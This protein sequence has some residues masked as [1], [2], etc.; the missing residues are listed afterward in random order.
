MHFVFDQ[1]RQL[2]HVCVANCDWLIKRLTR[3]T[4]EQLNLA[5]LGQTGAAQEV[6]HILD[7]QHAGDD[8]LVAVSPGHLVTC[9][10][11]AFLGNTDTYPLVD[12]RR[13]L[14]ASLAREHLDL[15]NRAALAVRHAQ[16]GISYLAG[17]LTEDGTQ[18]LFLGRRFRLALGG[19]PAHQDVLRPY[20]GTHIDD[21]V[22]IE[23]AQSLLADVGDISRDLFRPQPGV[24]GINLVLLDMNRREQVLA[25]NTLAD[26][27][28]VLEVATLPAHVG[29]QNILTKREF[30]VL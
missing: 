24:T 27:D 6:W 20:L 26:E 5:R 25:R 19:D 15:D 12:P 8:A 30:T 22:L 4:V 10:D 7:R 9:T 2:Q 28:G 16:R 23:V 1:V 18:Q 29:H 13:Q 11:L 21:A 14:I 3:A 17:L